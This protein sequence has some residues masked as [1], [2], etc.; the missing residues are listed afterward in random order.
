M[1]HILLPHQSSLLKSHSSLLKLPTSENVIFEL[2][3]G[4]DKKQT[5]SGVEDN[6]LGD[7]AVKKHLL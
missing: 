2:V 3:T 1:T 5:T 7:F 6:P 4:V